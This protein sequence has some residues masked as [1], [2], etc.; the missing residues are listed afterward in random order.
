MSQR[1]PAAAHAL[2]VLTLLARQPEP[3]AA[4]RIADSLG[5]PRSSTYH[6]LGVLAEHG[7]VVHLAEEQRWGLGQAVHELGSAY[8]RQAPMQR[9]ARPVLHRLVDQAGVSGHFGVLSGGD[10]LYLLE[11]RAPGQPS[12]VTD[13]GVRLP[14]HLTATGLAMLAHLPAAQIR[15]LYPDAGAFARRQGGIGPG[16]PSELRQSL[17]QVRSRG[18]AREVGIVT[19][20]FGSVACSVLDHTGHPVA[21]LTLTFPLADVSDSRWSDLAH[22]VSIAAERLTARLR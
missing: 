3:M 12:L 9:I 19:S 1:A 17:V 16:S 15:A 2:D 6:L 8:A 21:A 7:Y 20:G 10:V 4:S 5:L 18:H 11:V 14:A 13:V 22:L